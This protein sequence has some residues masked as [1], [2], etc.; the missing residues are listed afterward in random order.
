M[1]KYEILEVIGEGT[2][3]IVVK[4]INKETKQLV[5]IKKFKEIAKT[6]IKRELKMLN[7]L[8]S[9]EF[10]VNLKEAY[11]RKEKIYFIF[12]YVD[13]TLLQLLQENKNGLDQNLTRNIVFQLSKAIEKC[14]SLDIIHRDIK[15]ENLLIDKNNNLKLCDFG[16]ARETY[17]NGYEDTFTEYVATRWYRAPELILFCPY[18]KPVDIWAI[19]CIACE[20]SNSR[21]LFPGRSDIDQISLIIQLIGPLAE[22]QNEELQKRTKFASLKNLKFDS[23]ISLDSKFGALMDENMLDFVKKCLT[24]DPKNRITIEECIQHSVFENKIN[25]QSKNPKLDVQKSFISSFRTKE[26]KSDGRDSKNLLLKTLNSFNDTSENDLLIYNFLNSD[27]EIQ[28]TIVPKEDV[29]T[30]KQNEV[31]VLNTENKE[32]IINIKIPDQ[33]AQ[34]S[35][36]KSQI[37][38]IYIQNKLNQQ[39]KEADKLFFKSSVKFNESVSQISNKPKIFNEKLNENKLSITSNIPNV[40]KNQTKVLRSESK[41]ESSNTKTFMFKL[42]SKNDKNNAKNTKRS[43]STLETYKNELGVKIVRKA[44]ITPTKNFENFSTNQNIL[45]RTQFL[46]EDPNEKK[47][48]D[49]KLRQTP[50]SFIFQYFY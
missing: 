37:L 39:Q 18:G 11:R 2:Y 7:S 31:P 16:F 24:I 29:Q 1:N 28:K 30:T 21:A 26:L 45:N 19:G 47:K 32:N 41:Q 6:F 34:N 17:M 8:R 25:S 5:A 13:K 22:Y 43:F 10:I 40:N 3:G 9:C 49:L 50:V 46:K 35:Q 15:P 48:I 20:C 33:Q 14:H 38:N 44:S 27:F 42:D 4:A 36:K 23:K 12:E